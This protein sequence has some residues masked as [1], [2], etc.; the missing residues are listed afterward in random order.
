MTKA[1]KKSKGWIWN[2]VDSFEGDKVILMITIILMLISMLAISSSTSLLAIQQKSTRGAI[3]NEQLFI[4]IIGLIVIVLCYNIKRIAIFR[5][6]SQI[7]FIVS[8]CLL[9]ILDF[10][11]D[12]PILRPMSINSAK[13]ALNCFGFQVHVYEIV[14]VA[15]VMYIAWAV[16]AYKKDS[17]GLANALAKTER[18]AFMGKAIWKKIFYIYAPIMIVF[19]MIIGGSFSS[20]GFIAGILL[21]I[22]LFSGIIDHVKQIIGIGLIGCVL[23]LG[24]ITINRASNGKYF[25]HISSAINRFDIMNPDKKLREAK[26]T[27]EFSIVLDK[28][29]QPISAKV[30]ISE[31]GVIGKGAGKSTQRYVVPVMFEDFM[32]AFIVEEYGL[33]GAFLVLALYC[34]LVARGTIIVKTCDNTFA[35]IAIMG[36]VMLISGQALMHM[37]INVGMFP[38]TGQTLPM[39]S[40]GNSSFLMFSVAFGVILSISRMSKKK[41]EKIAKDETLAPEPSS[42]DDEIRASM[43]DL[44]NM[45]L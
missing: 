14:K 26:G 31:G 35:K 44:Y 1:A 20:A 40:H 9:A 41:I 23:I 42:E 43:D 30:A 25:S 3:I 33:I 15:M 12:N 34:S 16:N 7:G 28:V 22:V 4:E 17:F 5:M 39:I 8:F 45:D 2:F 38:L 27:D 24:G 32:Y 11:I 13:R 21:L 19:I 10:N 18:F 37:L 6:L 29:R 36:L